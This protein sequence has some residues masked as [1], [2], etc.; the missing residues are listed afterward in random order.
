MRLAPVPL[1]AVMCLAE[2]LT[3][4]GL[5]TF[6]ALLPDFQAE[7]G[8]DNT[9]AGWI[10]GA[11]FAGY[12]LG[13]PFL[14]AFTDRVDARLVYI[15]GAVAT[16]LLLAAFALWAEG[17]WSA[18][19]LRLAAGVALASTYMPG[20]RAI[21]DRYQ[22]PGLARGIAFYTASFSL[23]TA[24]SFF[25]SGEVGGALGWQW[26]FALAG[27]GAAIAALLA[28]LFL[29]PVRPAGQVGRAIL[30]F[31]PVL[32]NRAAMGYILAYAAHNWELFAFRSWLVAF[33][34]FSASQ[35]PA[36]STIWL[37]PA[38]VASL[39]AVIAMA[40]SILG[41]E[42]A[43]R[44]GRRRMIAIY[45]YA[46]GALAMVVGFTPEL[47]YAVVV[48]F[49]CLYS[50]TVQADSAALTIG[51]LTSSEPGRQGATLGLH[52]LVGFSGASVG[53][54]AVGL[55]LDIWGNGASTLSWGLAFATMGAGVLFGPLAFA[56]FRAGAA[57]SRG[58]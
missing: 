32:R 4:L 26:A 13:V 17:L 5:F 37:S 16:A 40:S 1:V 48:L 22:G 27:G 29:A 7:W 35:Q 24:V 43:N 31:R 30:D 3:L 34:A 52:A 19:A 42:A 55:V 18:L 38:A 8:L 57:A 46:S 56:A 25:A 9:A 50:V 14:T 39:V 6:A 23:G 15:A 54:L 28:I 33:L 41:G 51:C 10:A 20:L 58:D 47:P 21:S 45:M 53:P 2:V 11:S 12:A 44:W 36:G 49:M